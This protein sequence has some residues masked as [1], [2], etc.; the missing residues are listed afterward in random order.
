MSLYFDLAISFYFIYRKIK[1][2][3]PSTTTKR[4]ASEEI[5]EVED[6][7]KRSRSDDEN[8]TK[9]TNERKR[10]DEGEKS[11]DVASDLLITKYTKPTTSKTISIG[12]LST[13]RNLLKNLVK[14]KPIAEATA[15]VTSNKNEPKPSSALSLLAGYDQ[16]SDSDSSN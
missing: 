7:S 15:T 16:G 8:G 6:M 12:S 1:F 3:I 2:K 14:R 4:V 11:D 5:I 13:N 10:K 9:S